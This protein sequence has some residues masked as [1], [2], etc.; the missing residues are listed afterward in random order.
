MFAFKKL[1]VLGVVLTLLAISNTQAQALPNPSEE[2]KEPS[3][4]IQ[5]LKYILGWLKL[6]RFPYPGWVR[7]CNVALNIEQNKL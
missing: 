1:L 2:P 4:G 5:V 3:E 6:P 7:N